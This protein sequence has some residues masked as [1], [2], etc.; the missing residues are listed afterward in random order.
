MWVYD[1]RTEFIKDGYFK[2]TMGIGMLP[3]ANALSITGDTY[4]EG[5]LGI[6]TS[7]GSYPLDVYGNV[8]IDG[9]VGIGAN[10]L[11]GV[12]LYVSGATR[13]GGSVGIGVAPTSYA[14]DI[15]GS[16]RFD[17][18]VGIGTIPSSSTYRLDILGNFR[19]QGGI[20]STGIIQAGNGL[21]ASGGLITASAGI[22]ST[23]LTASGLITANAGITI[24]AGQTLTSTGTTILTGNVGIGT[25]SH[26]TYKVNVNGTLNATTLLMGGNPISGSKWTTATDT[27]EIY[28]NSGNVGIGTTD[29][30]CKLQIGI[31]SQ[32][33]PFITGTFIL[34]SHGDT[35]INNILAFGIPYR[36]SGANFPCNKINLYKVAGYGHGIGLSTDGVEYFTGG[37]YSSG[38]HVFYTGATDTSFGTARLKISSNGNI[39]IG[40]T[41]PAYKLH[42]RCSYG[43]ITSGLHLDAGETDTA[44]DKYTLTI[45]P[46]V[47]AGGEVGWRFRTQ[48][49]TGGTHTP[50]TLNNYGDVAIA[51]NLSAGGAIYT[52]NSYML[53]KEVYARNSYDTRIRSDSGGMYL[54]MGY[55]GSAG[56]LLKI[57][58]YNSVTNIDSGESRNIIMRTGGGVWVYTPYNGSFN[59]AG[60][61]YWTNPSDHR[62]KE[63]IKKANLK[64]CYDNIKN[65]NL[66]R[67]NYIDGYKKAT[68]Y[69]RTQLGFIAQ[70]VKQH[71]P[72]SIRR[73][74]MRFEDKREVPDLSVIDVAQVNYSLFGAVKQLIRVVEKQSKRIKKLEEMLNIIDDDEVEDDA[75]EP[76]IRINCEDEVDIDD[77]E[78]SEPTE[79]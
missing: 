78:P 59:A 28:Y 29:P 13:L 26:A 23:T 7:A 51:R 62:I 9:D 16:S 30:L 79:V 54:E 64:M 10:P 66:Y 32:V 61:I 68:Q 42:V 37:P 49:F 15:I 8:N 71:Y 75:D 67:F 65:I 25:T 60:S 6:N 52:D 2:G 34:A 20:V 55:I 24:P 56:G 5:S 4:M 11:A 74:K 50:L 77:I 31:A 17:G 1:K 48:N 41:N 47:I 33:S 58:A 27:T 22:S 43:V 53:A 12:K 46:F 36:E 18:Y 39:G 38:N 69:D 44:T 21:T 57:G 72:K 63:N 19:T 14:F 40:N 35:F 3:N 73:E 45:Y 76:Y 70:Q